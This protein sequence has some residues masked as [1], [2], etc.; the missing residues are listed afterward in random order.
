MLALNSWFCGCLMPRG[1]EISV[2]L[3]LDSYM[4]SDLIMHHVIHDI[5]LMHAVL[6]LV[7]HEM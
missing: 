6:D 3:I 2:I 1:A 5:A 7:R 4:L